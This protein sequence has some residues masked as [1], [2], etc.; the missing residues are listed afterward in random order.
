MGGL[1]FIA[2]VIGWIAACVWMTSKIS[3]WLPTKSGW[4]KGLANVLVFALI[5][6]LPLIDEIIGKIQ[7]DK[8]CHKEAGIKVYSK[9]ELGQEFF[10]ADGT[11]NFFTGN[12]WFGI[13]QRVDK[14]VELNV[15]K[16]QTISSLSN[17]NRQVIYIRNR[18]TGESIA[19][20]TTFINRGG[21]LSYEDNA[22]L[23]RSDCSP[24]HTPR[25]AL[26]KALL[27]TTSRINTK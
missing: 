9:L 23:S 13:D 25:E 14:L 26:T 8:L 27:Q 1:I 22:W 15:P 12:K 20:I 17:L 19:S 4:A 11:P 16:G 10:H 3:G 18:K 7:F 6:P 2:V 24:S 5:F 21:W